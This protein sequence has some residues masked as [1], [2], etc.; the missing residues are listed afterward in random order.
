[1]STLCANPFLTVPVVADQEQ[2]P[3]PLRGTLAV[4]FVFR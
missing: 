4:F 1:M 2:R 3:W